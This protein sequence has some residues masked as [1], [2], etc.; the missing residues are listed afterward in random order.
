MTHEQW[1][2]MSSEEQQ[3]KVAKL[4]GW[5]DI[6]VE[7]PKDCYGLR[8]MTPNKTHPSYSGNDEDGW[9]ITIPDYLHDLNVMYEAEETLNPGFNGDSVD[10]RWNRYMRKLSETAHWKLSLLHLTAA[11]RAEAFVLSMTATPQ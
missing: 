1:V 2:K 10:P 5:R 7:M 4:C 11:Q 3:I 9:R 6:R 8:G